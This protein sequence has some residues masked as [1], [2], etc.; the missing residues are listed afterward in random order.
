M[1][2]DKMNGAQQIKT[3]HITG[4]LSH[5]LS[6][7]GNAGLVVF[8]LAGDGGSFGITFPA[9][10]AALIRGL[11]QEI[12]IQHMKKGLPSGMPLFHQSMNKKGGEEILVGH[13]DQK[14]GFSFILISPGTAEEYVVEVTN[15][16][17]MM[18]ADLLAKDIEPRL[19]PQEREHRLMI[20][21]KNSIILPGQK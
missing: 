10:Q 3:V 5:S 9:D 20:K 18:L 17:G 15:L 14:R 4:C 11:F 2:E 12:A 8:K 19:T 16:T 21:A 7:D 13:A 6:T 1:T